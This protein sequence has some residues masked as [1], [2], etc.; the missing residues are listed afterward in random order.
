M[1]DAE[2]DEGRD[3]YERDMD[4]YTDEEAEVDYKGFRGDYAEWMRD[5]DKERM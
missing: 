5:Y 1:W 4:V 2:E 3:W